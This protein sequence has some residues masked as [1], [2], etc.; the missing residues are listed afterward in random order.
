MRSLILALPADV[1]LDDQTLLRFV[2][3]GQAQGEPA[4]QDANQVHAGESTAVGQLPPADELVLVLP[5]QCLSWQRLDL[6]RVPRARLPQA[7][8]GLLEERLLSDPAQL[9]FAVAPDAAPGQPTWVAVCD[10]AWLRQTLQFFESAGRPVSRVVPQA[11]PLPLSLPPRWQ[12]LGHPGAAWLLRWA[13]D[14]VQCLPFDALTADWMQIDPAA[15]QAEPPL[16]AWA[17]QVA[18]GPVAVCS[19]SQSLLQAGQGHWDLAQFDLTIRNQQRWL[20][21]ALR[22]WQTWLAAPAWRPLRWGLL[23]CVAMQVVGL[24][25][26][27]WQERANLQAKQAE[28]GQLLTRHFPALPVVDP[29]LQMQ[30]EL[31]RLQRAT[32]ALAPDDLEA[33]LAAVAHGAPE[34]PSVTG[35][36]Y[37]SQS[38]TLHGLELSAEAAA[39]LAERLTRIGYHSEFTGK[40]L[41]VQ[42]AGTAGTAP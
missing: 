18:G 17:E 12:V 30:R 6:P 14:G 7:L 42:R 25:A 4:G 20:S 35:L 16:A 27:A 22:H 32:S 33:L 8:A 10:K 2:L 15:T 3:A 5:A 13:D 28:L 41:H 29:V 1:R 36:S 11:A 39:S 19:P 24:N 40:A 34:L 26:W 37:Q 23:A 21:S 31:S 9:H 38:L